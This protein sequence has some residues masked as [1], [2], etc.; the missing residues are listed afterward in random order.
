ME[1]IAAYWD[2]AQVYYV[3]D[4]KTTSQLGKIQAA[5]KRVKGLYGSC[6]VN[7]FTPKSLKAV[8]MAILSSGAS[9]KYINDLVQIIKNMFK[10]GVS[11][12]LVPNTAYQALC[13]VDGLRKGRTEAKEP[14]PIAPVEIAVVEATISYLPPVVAAIVQFQRFTGCRPGEACQL[15]PMDLKRSD[16]IWEYRPASHK[17]QHHNKVRVIFVGPRL[18]PSFC[19][20]SIA[21]LI[22]TVLILARQFG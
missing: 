1:L 18:N 21:L 10:W 8:R 17:N 9:R 7:E 20:T 12:E 2:H 19:R 22:V 14:E 4:G 3:K 15:W 5:M 11:E 16:E 6:T 13:T